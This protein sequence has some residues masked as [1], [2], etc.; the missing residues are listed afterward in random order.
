LL[1][2]G[3]IAPDELKLGMNALPDGTIIQKDGSISPYLFTLGTNLK[4]ILWESTAVPELRVQAKQLAEEVI[5]QLHVVKKKIF[6]TKG[7]KEH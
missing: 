2:R 4:G 1:K 6:T 3:F 5:R 7:T